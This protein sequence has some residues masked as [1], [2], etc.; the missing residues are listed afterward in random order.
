[1]LFLMRL[2]V[3]E[4]YDA[5]SEYAANHVAKRIKQFAPVDGR[6]FVLGRQDEGAELVW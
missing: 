6:Q 4:D 5:V 2:I 3:V 1:M